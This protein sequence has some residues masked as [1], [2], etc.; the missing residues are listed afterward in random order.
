MPVF[1]SEFIRALRIYFC[2]LFYAVYVI[3]V[4]FIN[5]LKQLYVD[6]NSFVRKY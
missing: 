1:V 2:K 6:L 5:C 3:L 4:H